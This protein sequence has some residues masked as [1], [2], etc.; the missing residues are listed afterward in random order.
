MVKKDIGLYE[1]VATLENQDANT[2]KQISEIHKV[3]VG[4]GKPGIVNEFNKWKGFSKGF[5]YAFSF[6][7]L[8]LSIITAI[9]II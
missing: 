3:L 7:L 9:K 6:I 1:R 2:A 5:A 4:N 8:V